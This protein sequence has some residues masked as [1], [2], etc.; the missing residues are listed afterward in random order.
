MA[1]IRAPQTDREWEDYFRL[2]W[3]VL[4][5]P[6]G[7][8]FGSEKDEF[9]ASATHRCALLQQ[10]MAGVGRIHAI[11]E[12][13]AQIR[14][15][16]TLPAFR[17]QGIGSAILVSLEQHAQEMGKSEIILNARIPCLDFYLRMGYTIEGEGPTLFSSIEHKRLKKALTGPMQT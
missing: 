3:R 9:E 5:E 10:T 6:W 13:Q 4:R 2:R 1:E 15:M 11:S 17:H 16:A 7:Q 12:Q 14:Y 8:A